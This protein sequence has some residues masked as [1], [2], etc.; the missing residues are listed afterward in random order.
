MK[1]SITILLILVFYL[2]SFYLFCQEKEKEKKVVYNF[3]GHSTVGV[4]VSPGKNNVPLDF[5]ESN[6]CLNQVF[7]DKF[8][9]SYRLEH[10]GFGLGVGW[11]DY[12]YVDGAVG[13]GYVNTL[14]KELD[15]YVFVAPS[16]GVIYIMDRNNS[17]YIR[18]SVKYDR[19]LALNKIVNDSVFYETGYPYREYVGYLME[20]NKNFLKHVLN[21]NFC[22]TGFSRKILYGYLNSE[23]LSDRVFLYPTNATFFDFNL[24]LRVYPFK[25]DMGRR[26]FGFN[27]SFEDRVGI[28]KSLPTFNQIIFHIGVDI[29]IIL[30][31]DDWDVPNSEFTD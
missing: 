14:N 23:P 10:L 2:N 8:A 5:S 7:S 1:F 13:Q 12:N 28:F 25:N 17:D 4:M 22:L 27:F 16:F 21:L 20:I 19:L 3:N 29:H 6:I 18:L 30:N 24:K 11:G 9:L 31:R 26:W 15:H